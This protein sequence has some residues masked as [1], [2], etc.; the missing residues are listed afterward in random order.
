MT[1]DAPS[2]A[3]TPGR[4][5]VTAAAL[6]PARAF[7]GGDVIDALGRAYDAAWNT[8]APSCS[9]SPVCSSQGPEDGTATSRTGQDGVWRGGRT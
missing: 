9:S 4:T 8:V 3:S 1:H 6:A 7:G 2:P 5:L